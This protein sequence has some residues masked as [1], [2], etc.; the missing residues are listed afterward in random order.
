MCEGY[1]AEVRWQGG[2]RRAHA[3]ASSE[4]TSRASNVTA[5]SP[6]VPPVR[7][8]VEE[9]PSW[10]DDITFDSNFDFL[11]G[12]QT[13][14][15]DVS[16]DVQFSWDT[17][18]VRSPKGPSALTLQSFRQSST[19]PVQLPFLI[20][21]IESDMEQK[22]FCHFTNHVSKILT[23]STG[24]SNPFVSVIVLWQ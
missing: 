18:V 9:R 17:A 4:T 20:N 6:L 2:S 16:E 5:Q 19:L 15:E 24:A 7:V 10:Q 11:F 1:P 23:L 8:C 14:L 12:D 21:G 13:L 22:L 3:H